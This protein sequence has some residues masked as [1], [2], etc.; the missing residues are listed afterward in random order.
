MSWN[1]EVNRAAV[2]A[3]STARAASFGFVDL[4]M[5][6]GGALMFALLKVYV[7]VTGAPRAAWRRRAS[8]RIRK[9]LTELNDQVLDDIG[10]ARKDIAAVSRLSAAD[11]GTSFRNF[12][13]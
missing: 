10:I 5:H 12:A 6:L 8:H 13:R 4:Q 3:G 9:E 11:P 1:G 7:W 2:V